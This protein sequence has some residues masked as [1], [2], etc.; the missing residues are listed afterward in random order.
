MP[1]FQ[2]LKN[3][4]AESCKKPLVMVALTRGE[5]AS[6]RAELR[7]L[8][9]GTGYVIVSNLEKAHSLFGGAQLS[10]VE[11][12]ST[13]VISGNDFKTFDDLVT[14]KSHPLDGSEVA[15]LIGLD[16]DLA[17]V[18]AGEEV[19]C[20][21]TGKPTKLE[22]FD[23]TA[24]ASE[25]DGEE[26]D[27]SDIDMSDEEEDAA[28][29]EPD[30]SAEDEAAGGEEDDSE[31]EDMSSDDA[32]NEDI[33]D[34]E[35]SGDPSDEDTE[36]SMELSSD[37]E[38]NPFTIAGTETKALLDKYDGAV[39]V[40]EDD[41]GEPSLYGAVVR[42]LAEDT[43]VVIDEDGV[44]YTVKTT[45]I[46]DDGDAVKLVGSL[47][48]AESASEQ[49]VDAAETVDLGENQVRLMSMTGKDNSEVAVFVGQTHVATLLRNRASEVAA[50]L[51][52]NGERL[53][54]AFKP[55]L[56]ANFGNS[57]SSELAK[58]GYVPV[59]FKVK[60]HKL[61]E[62]RVQREIA[63]V[64]KTTETAAA[65]RFEDFASNLE[66]A[67]VGINKG[68]FKVKNEL[69]T[70]IAGLLRR[71][72]VAQPEVETRKLLAKHTKSYVGA[73]IEQAKILNDKPKEYL[74]GLTDTLKES[75]FLVTETASAPPVQHIPTPPR[76]RQ[77]EIAG[78]E[79][80]KGNQPN[81]FASLIASIRR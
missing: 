4:I 34:T 74:N 3:E 21:V 28:E 15:Q 78:F 13:R 54:A 59:T 56:R 12:A 29:G 40:Y 31:E 5:V 27:V 7:A 51:F 64:S 73:A 77:P 48:E 2:N 70:E 9:D 8:T 43:F 69:A 14:M 19:N 30:D 1:D 24:M 52:D 35:D 10:P 32:A 49:E 23:E 45:T 65:T 50:P 22:Y 38:S 63:R 20:P 71:A 11:N 25:D 44:A 55:T 79:E 39:T 66:I 33:E 81:R 26:E 57:K 42:V 47:Q 61:F 72:G 16:T 58:F 36:D 68:F 37:D 17:F 62:K 53:M 80:N 75:A 6:K 18:L 60:V 67:F 46:G 76:E 41:G